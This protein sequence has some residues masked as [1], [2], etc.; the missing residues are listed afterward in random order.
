MTSAPSIP[1]SAAVKKE[2][3]QIL[4]VPLD[5]S[6]LAEYALSVAGTI[7]HRRGMKV[8]LVSVFQQIPAFLTSLAGGEEVLADPG[9]ERERRDEFTRYLKT[10][11]EGLATTHGVDTT[12]AL[13]E[14]APAQALAEHARVRHAGMIVMTTH[15]HGGLNRL[16]LGSVADSLLRRVRVP[17]LLQRPRGGP[18]HTE[19]RHTLIALD[20]SVEGE[21]V[22]EPAAELGSLTRNAQFTLV[23]VVEPPIAVITRL[24]MSP[25]KLRPNWREV[26]ENCVRSYL[27]RVASRLRTHGLQ[28]KTEMIFARGAGE[29]IAEC[30][31][32]IGADLIA[33][34][35][36]GAGGMERMLLGSV[37]DK[38]IRAAQQTVLVV[39][40]RKED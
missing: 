4:L 3:E 9:L 36:H 5:G 26:Q 19:F 8:H 13:L 21:D 38:V 27:E 40:I 22:I 35:T 16:W 2:R 18:P 10:T 39:P 33:V 6:S 29:Q 34:G 23:Q 30:A 32:S 25:A 31:R 1:A 7:A 15:G 14:G 28:V 24:A 12:F 17:V 37:A 11:A 20:G